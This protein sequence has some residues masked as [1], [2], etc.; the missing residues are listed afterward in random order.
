MSAL[1]KAIKFFKGGT[2]V[3]S[4]NQDFLRD[5]CDEIW[6]VEDGRVSI[7]GKDGALKSLAAKNAALKAEKQKQKLEALKV[8]EEKAMSGP[9]EAEKALQVYLDAR[10]KLGAPKAALLQY[11]DLSHGTSAKSSKSMQKPSAHSEV[12]SFL[13]ISEPKRAS[14]LDRITINERW[15]TLNDMFLYN[16][17]MFKLN[18]M[19][20]SIGNCC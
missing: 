13:I 2:I 9:S 18:L 17:D 1:G 20:L 3:V 16:F 14:A 6:H 15:N 12:C 4:H 11:E 19:N 7:E 5:T 8:K 10:Q